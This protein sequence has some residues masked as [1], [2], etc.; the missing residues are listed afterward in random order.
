[1]SY[2][3]NVSITVK[4]STNKSKSSNLDSNLD[5]KLV[6]IRFVKSSNQN[7]KFNQIRHFSNVLKVD[8]DSFDYAI[9][10]DNINKLKSLL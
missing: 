10:K 7:S 5:N 2:F 3:S 6:S 8:K 1:V 9:Y 4:S